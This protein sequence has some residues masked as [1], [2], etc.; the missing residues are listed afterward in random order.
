MRRYFRKRAL[1]KYRRRYSRKLKPE[2]KQACHILNV[3][4][5]SG[6]TGVGDVTQ[7]IPNIGQGTT[8]G[9]RVGDCISPISLHIKGV[10]SCTQASTAPGTDLSLGRIAARIMIV[11]PRP[12]Q[13]LASSQ[14]AFSGWYD[15]LLRK[16]ISTVGFTG[17]Q[18]D[19]WAD[20]NRNAFK[21]Y[22]DKVIYLSRPINTSGSGFFGEAS[23]ARRLNIKFK[24]RNKKWKYDPID[25]I[26]GL[27][28]LNEPMVMLVGYAYI[29][30]TVSPDVL[31]TNV[32][33]NA[34]CK[35]KYFDA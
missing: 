25:Q 26:G 23:H 34:D 21:V 24:W 32:S 13:G 5:N 19:V 35:V 12:Y 3:Q 7:I 29:G 31:S 27:Q 33:V 30:S 9:L 14:S 10:I 11:A 20:I 1:R 4:Y 2:V 16:G 17:V 18:S 15:K 6:V 22:Y 8:D 28:P